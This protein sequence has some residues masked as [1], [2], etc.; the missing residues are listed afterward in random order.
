MPWTYRA[1]HHFGAAFS[2]LEAIP[3]LPIDTSPSI[4]SSWSE[5]LLEHLHLAKT[6]L[7]NSVNNSKLFQSLYASGCLRAPFY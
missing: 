3:L 5:G 4:L 2:D 7:S 1:I 6:M